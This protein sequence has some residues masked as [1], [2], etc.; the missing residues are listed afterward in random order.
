TSRAVPCICPHVQRMAR[1]AMPGW[2]SDPAIEAIEELAHARER[3]VDVELARGDRAA[4]RVEPQGDALPRQAVGRERGDRLGRAGEWLIPRN[5]DHATTHA[6]PHAGAEI[7]EREL[8]ALV[9][10]AGLL[11]L[12]ARGHG[13]DEQLD[14]DL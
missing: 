8:P 12:Q 2:Y 14:R 1:S 5:L 3:A 10:L 11:E 7:G 9:D 13:L 6:D 4:G